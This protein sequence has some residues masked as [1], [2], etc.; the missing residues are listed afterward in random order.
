MNG[1]A[2]NEA[3]IVFFWRNETERIGCY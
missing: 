3:A 2:S 1:N